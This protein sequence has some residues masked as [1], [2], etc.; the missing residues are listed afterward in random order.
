M[1][2]KKPSVTRQPQDKVELSS[3]ARYASIYFLNIGIGQYNN[4]VDFFELIIEFLWS[5]ISKFNFLYISVANI[6]QTKHL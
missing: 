4:R 1:L 6:A 2:R 3:I 5:L